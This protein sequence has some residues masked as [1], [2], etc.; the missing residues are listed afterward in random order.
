MRSVSALAFAAATLTLTLAL[1]AVAQQDPAPP[2]DGGAPPAPGGATLTLTPGGATPT[3]SGPKDEGT[4]REA[5]R[6][7][8]KPLVWRGS[9]ILFD[10]SVTPETVGVGKDLQSDNPSYQLWISFRPRV[11]LYQDKVQS[12][13]VN[14]RMD[15]YK[16]LT[17]SD[18]TTKYRQDVFGDIW[19]NA[20]YSHRVYKGDSVTTRLSIGPRLL[21]PTSLESRAKNVIVTA[22]VSGAVANDFKL[23]KDDGPFKTARAN[24]SMAYTHPFSK[25]KVSTGEA[26]AERQRRTTDDSA[27]APSM[28]A[29]T[30]M[31]NQLSGGLLAEHQLLTIFDTGIQIT[32]KLG[33][34]LDMIFISQW[35]YRPDGYDGCTSLTVQTGPTG[36]IGSSTANADPPRYNLLTWF[37]LGPDYQLTPELN[38]SAGYYH[39]T[40]SIGPDGT[41]RNVLYSP[42]T[43]RLY[44]SA[45]VE[46]DSLY[47]RLSGRNEDEGKSDKRISRQRVIPGFGS[48]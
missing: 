1:P 40:N 9:S 38:L 36:C 14:L 26:A 13:N 8:K 3:Q 22:G 33:F 41:R 15:Y 37:L 4:S 18:D 30:G 25:Y 7:E 20:P 35:K 39:L 17:N 48:Y 27:Q 21:L 2:A 45:T 16:E 23:H 11:V 47:E 12:F 32:E 28:D 10:Q 19:V 6:R 29:R 43:A 46:L 31:N 24:F 44:L 5:T 34:T 42:D